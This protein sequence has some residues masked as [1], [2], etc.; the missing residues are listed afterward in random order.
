MKRYLPIVMAPLLALGLAAGCGSNEETMMMPGDMATPQN[1]PVIE[2]VAPLTGPPSGGIDITISGRFFQPDPT[3][4]KVTFGSQQAMPIKSLTQSQVVV[5][6]PPGMRGPVDVTVQNGNGQTASQAGGFTYVIDIPG[7]CSTDGWCVWNQPP[8]AKP[9]N[10]VRGSNANHIWAVGDDGYIMFWNGMKWTTQNSNTTQTLEGVF[11]VDSMNVWAVGRGGVIL[12]TTNGGMTWTSQTS[13]V[14]STLQ[15]VYAVNNMTAWAVGLNGVIRKTTDGGTNWGMQTSGT[16]ADLNAI[17][18]NDAMTAWVA[19]E[20]G[21]IH[22]TTN[23]GTSWVMQNSNT[24]QDLWSI[25]GA[26]GGTLWA[27][28]AGG[29]IVNTTNGGLAWNAQVSSTTTV[30]LGLYAA[31]AQ[32]V[33]AAGY[34]GVVVRT[35]NGGG[36]WSSQPANTPFDFN[37]IWG[38]GPSN[39]FALGDY[40]SRVYDG[41]EWAGPNPVTQ[42][43]LFTLHGSDANHMWAVGDGG[44]IA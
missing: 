35:T 26:S 2:N 14:T 22:S 31:D 41:T 44:T 11:A 40:V 17:H 25:T 38:S 34:N 42:Q 5:T 30:L 21:T 19:G 23:G 6:L 27:A 7:S 13:G 33:W 16:T 1:A 20:A 3:T 28:G 24:T 37:A 32:N 8:A 29:A 39:I 10:S 12:R 4:F 43:N 9:I 15:A 18:A 36:A